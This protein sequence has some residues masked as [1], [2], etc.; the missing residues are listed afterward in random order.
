MLVLQDICKIYPGT[1]ALHKV[2]LDVKKGEVHGIIGKNG[3]GKSTLVG[4]I[5]G[6]TAP[7]KG[8]IRVNNKSFNALTRE[9]AKKEG[10]AI[11]PQEPQVILDFTVAENLFVGNY[12]S[13]KGKVDWAEM[14]QR[15]AKIFER[16]N[17]NLNLQLIAR[18][19]SVSEQQLLLIL[20]ACFVENARIIIL[21]EA[22]AS[23]SQK[24]QELL[25]KII[26]E[27][28]KEGKTILFI[29]HRTDEL[30]RICDRVTVIRDGWSVATEDCRRLD[31]QKLSALIVGENSVFE[32]PVTDSLSRRNGVTEEIF[33]LEDFTRAGCFHHIN[34][35]LQRGEVLGLAGLRGSGRTEI[36]KSIIGIDPVDEGWV[37][38]D[39][40]RTRF[41]SPSQA[42]KAGIAYLPE[43]R[44]MEGL[45]PSFSTRANLI[46][47]ALKKISR[48][49]VIVGRR[50]GELVKQLISSVGIKVAAPEQEVSQLSGGN[51][52]KVVVGRILATEPRIYLL[53]E[54]TKG[55]DIAAKESI[56]RIIK[57]NLSHSAG[58]IITSPG[59]D[60]LMLICDRILVLYRG[61]IIAEFQRERFTEE[62]IFLAMQGVIEGERGAPADCVAG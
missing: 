24:D 23:L 47:N 54:P 5:A 2:N 32:G 10:I 19:L 39:G 61:R 51:R 44:D 43:D 36:F 27:K 7:T 30:L 33:S 13:R 8:V 9:L 28:K 31:K 55:V 22:S 50:E 29:S 6:V 35:R 41:A 11:V 48:A 26:E 42:L 53:D 16:V 46:L 60:D 15:A 34:I 45:I 38:I 58:V 56:L 62:A 37:W 20:R 1:I 49:F 18:D 4:I 17:L 12:L 14:K 59:I 40:K 25:F 3:A 52:Q 57:E 21:D